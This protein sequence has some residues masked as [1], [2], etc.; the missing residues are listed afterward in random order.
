[1]E[2]WHV[3]DDD[4]SPLG[5]KSRINGSGMVK[6]NRNVSKNGPG[7]LRGE[8]TGDSH[9]SPELT[10]GFPLC[11]LRYRGRNSGLCLRKRMIAIYFNR[12]NGHK[13]QRHK[14]CAK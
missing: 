7:G 13:V 8:W 6:G 14:L 3:F 2:G 12:K 10:C 1:M 11:G 9:A 5:N 4:V